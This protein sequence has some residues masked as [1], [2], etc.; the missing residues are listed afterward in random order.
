R[1][2]ATHSIS[3]SPPSGAERAGV[4]WGIPGRSPTPTSPSPPP[5]ARG[6][7]PPPPPGAPPQHPP[8]PPPGGGGGG[9]G[10]GGDSRALA[11]AHLTL[12]IAARW[13]PSLSPLK[14]GEGF[15]SR[16]QRQSGC[17]AILGKL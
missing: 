4:R 3:P 1:S 13:V 8:P 5:P 9:G 12:P 14:G 11:N 6:P 17:A 15:S 10:G 2:A 16:R 7:P